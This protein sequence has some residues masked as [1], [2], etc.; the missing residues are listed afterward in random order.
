MKQRLKWGIMKE[1][2]M[3]K[4]I[5]GERGKTEEKEMKEIKTDYF[6]KLQFVNKF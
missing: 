5:E 3:E 2:Q 6:G 1:K 4:E